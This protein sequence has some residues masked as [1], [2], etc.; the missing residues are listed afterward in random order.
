MKTFLI[1]L[2][3]FTFSEAHAQKLW[4]KGVN[5]IC[6]QTANDVDEVK[7]SLRKTHSKDCDYLRDS[8]R[9]AIGHFFKCPDEKTHSYFRSKETCEM[10]FAEGKKQLVKFAPSGSV[11]PKKWVKNFGNCMETATQ[12][13]VNTMG[14]R[15]LNI[16][17]YCVAGNTTDKVTG[18]IVQECSKNL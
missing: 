16:F 13:Q 15:L 6:V 11:N 5:N 7:A 3:I 4:E 14:L 10:F 18:H 17:C 8:T 9:V 1:L 2:C 12:Q